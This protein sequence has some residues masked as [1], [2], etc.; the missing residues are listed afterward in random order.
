[1]EKHESL[2]APPDSPFFT[3]STKKKKTSLG[4]GDDR[5]PKPESLDTHNSPLER[6]Y[7]LANE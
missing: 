1:M 3:S 6:A 7:L 5:S 4:K 2:D